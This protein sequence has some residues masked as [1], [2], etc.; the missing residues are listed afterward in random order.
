MASP[1]N[2]PQPADNPPIDPH[3]SN[4]SQDVG[5]QLLL[6]LKNSMLIRRCMDESQKA[7]VVRRCPA[8]AGVPE[9]S[10]LFQSA[11]KYVG[12]NRDVLQNRLLMMAHEYAKEWISTDDGQTWIKGDGKR[13]TKVMVPNCH[14]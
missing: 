5:A 1:S 13:L 12:Y 10:V 9:D 4:L 2:S 14:L 11:K 8:L 7:S 6:Y 3:N